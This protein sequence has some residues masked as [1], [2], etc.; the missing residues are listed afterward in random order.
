MQGTAYTLEDKRRAAVAV[1][2]YGA[3]KHAAKAIGMPERTLH[4]WIDGPEWPDLLQQV[5]SEARAQITGEVTELYLRLLADMRTRL[6]EGDEVMTRD[7]PQRLAVRF[8]DL[9][10]GASIMFQQRQI[11]TNAP[12]SISGSSGMGEVAAALQAFLDNAR[13]AAPATTLHIDG[14]AERLPPDP[15]P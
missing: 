10:I 3:V 9:S 2:V 11:L 7:G 12:T 15:A 8:R 4:S 5:S 13:T 14:T 1:S 6:E